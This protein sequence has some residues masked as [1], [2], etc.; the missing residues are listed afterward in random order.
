L[1]WLHFVSNGNVQSTEVEH[2]DA[3]IAAMRLCSFDRQRSV[4]KG[5]LFCRYRVFRIVR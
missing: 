5:I 2:V 4:V 3:V 1:G